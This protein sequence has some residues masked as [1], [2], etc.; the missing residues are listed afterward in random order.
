MRRLEQS[1]TTG[2]HPS[3]AASRDPELVGIE[4]ARLEDCLKRPIN[5]SRQHYLRLR[6][7]ETYRNLLRHGIRADYTMGYGDGVGWRAGTNQPFPWYDLEKEKETRLRVH[8][9]AAMD[10]TLRN[11]LGFTAEE[12][13]RAVLSIYT[14]ALPYGGPFM[15]LWHN[16][17]FAPDYGWED[18]KDMYVRLVE[19][20][21]GASADDTA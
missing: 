21:S 11:Y 16:S 17:S 18:W 12:A 10:V 20:L 8:P 5:R 3:Y 9:F 7:P 2:L 4:K 19:R 13:E 15:L 14:A 6:I 1:S